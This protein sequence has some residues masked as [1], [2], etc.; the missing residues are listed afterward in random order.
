MHA[1]YDE[2]RGADIKEEDRKVVNRKW[3]FYMVAGIIV[4]V[5]L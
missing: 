3:G 1:Q 2:P 5:R 4:S